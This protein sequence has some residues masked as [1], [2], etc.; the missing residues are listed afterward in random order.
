MTEE[1]PMT[2]LVGALRNHIRGED[3]PV[4]CLCIRCLAASKIERL[5]KDYERWPIVVSGFTGVLACEKFSIFHADVERVLGRPV[6]THQM[7]DLKVAEEIK[8][9]YR[10]EFFELT[11]RTVQR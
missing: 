10:A 2:D 11:A 4:P 6:W 3:E 1:I 7:A 9:A 5:Q 8:E